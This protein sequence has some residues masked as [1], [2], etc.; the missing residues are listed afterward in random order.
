LSTDTSMRGG[1]SETDATELAVIPIGS[2]VDD[3]LVNT[4]TPVAKRPSS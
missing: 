1:S 2:P 3:R 4:V